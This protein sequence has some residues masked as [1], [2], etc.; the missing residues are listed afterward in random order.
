[1]AVFD[2]NNPGNYVAADLLS[3]TST[4]AANYT[5][6][7]KAKFENYLNAKPTKPQDN[8]SG[9]DKGWNGTSG[10]TDF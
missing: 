5:A 7:D 9:G 6:K 1:M 4:Y 10:R 3:G 2:I 8:P